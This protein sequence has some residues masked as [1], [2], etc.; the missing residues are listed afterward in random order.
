MSGAVEWTEHEGEV[1]AQAGRF[2]LSVAYQCGDIE[3]G[4]CY[5]WSVEWTDALD[6]TRYEDGGTTLTEDGAREAAERALRDIEEDER[7]EGLQP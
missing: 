4:D 2:S 6:G 3:D 5:R 1:M 7:K